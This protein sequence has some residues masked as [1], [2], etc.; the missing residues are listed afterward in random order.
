[1]YFVQPDASSFIEVFYEVAGTDLLL[2]F[3]NGQQNFGS[4][5]PSVRK[6][7]RLSTLSKTASQIGFLPCRA[8]NL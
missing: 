4:N 1:M 5:T 7:F 3:F 2:E 6:I 8:L